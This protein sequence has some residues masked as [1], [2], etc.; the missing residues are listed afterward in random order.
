MSFKPLKLLAEDKDD[1]TSISAA[2]QDAVGQLG[3]FSYEP[4][5][6]RFTLALNRFRWEAGDAGRGQRVRTAV[7]ANGVLS[8]QGMRLKQTSIEAVVNLLSISF[9]PGEEPG[10]ALIFTFSGGGA[11]RLEVECVDLLM[12]DLTDPWRAAGRPS[13]PDDN[14]PS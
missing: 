1:L 13:H 6:R 12:A 8:A 14:E 10:G 2:L 9:E 4:K 5:H 3:D 11:L 7:Q